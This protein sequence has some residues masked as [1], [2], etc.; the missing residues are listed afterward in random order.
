M[1]R[2]VHILAVL[3]LVLPLSS[4]ATSVP[5]ASEAA[6]LAEIGAESID[7]GR[8]GPEGEPELRLI[9]DVEREILEHYLLPMDPVRLAASA[10]EGM[11][12]AAGGERVTAER[13]GDSVR[14]Q[15]GGDVVVLP[16]SRDERTNRESLTAAYQ[17]IRKQ[18][19][20]VPVKELAYDAIDRMLVQLDAHSSFMPPE[21]YKEMQLET[22]GRFGGVGIQI[23]VKDRQLAIVAPIPGTPADRARLQPGD[24]ILSI[25]GAAVREMT[26]TEAVH[27]LR[28]PPGTKVTLSI[29]RED[30]PGPF[31]ITLTR[32]IIASKPVEVVE[33]EHAVGYIKVTS[34][35]EQSGRDLHQAVQAL[36]DKAVRGLILDLRS[37]RGGLFNESVRTAELFL[38]AGQPVVSTTSRHR[39]ESAQYRTRHTG[40]LLAIPMI[41]LVDGSSASASEIVAGALQDL[42]RALIVGRQTYGKGS[43]QTIIPLSDGSALRLTTARYLT[44]QGRSIDGVGIAPDLT[45]EDRD[46]EKS[47]ASPGGYDG[48]HEKK[49]KER[50]RVMRERGRK[51]G[52]ED[53][54][55][56]VVIGRRDTV[57]L[58]KDQP[59]ALAWRTLLATTGA[60]VEALLS[61][62]KR[63]QP[64]Q[65]G[66]ELDPSVGPPPVPR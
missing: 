8:A 25:D 10:I 44:P 32:E 18:A 27:R 7:L 6:R 56:S 24:R 53:G 11:S 9:Q 30:S 54:D 16:L 41:V 48:A 64:L 61:T 13:R 60:D 49:R 29:L 65:R 26:L 55:P 59:L 58:Q 66:A 20:S 3:S 17:F 57:D 4:G 33:L 36:K 45:V 23:A 14:L 22:Q 50:S 62:A 28:G 43:V 51:I 47:V 2:R 19:P 37:N 38:P 12:L 1:R 40:A 35:S 39:R 52:E 34:F 31:R 5:P 42:K 21:V 15:V 46:A 63:L